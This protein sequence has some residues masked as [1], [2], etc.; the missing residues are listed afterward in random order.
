MASAKPSLPFQPPPLPGA[1]ADLPM[2][3]AN[4]PPRSPNCTTRGGIPLRGRWRNLSIHAENHFRNNATNFRLRCLIFMQRRI[5]S[6]KKGFTLMELLVVMAII[7]ILAALL[8]PALS[9]ILQ[10]ARQ[11]QCVNN[12][13][14][15][16]I[17]L[18]GF[19]SDNHVYPLVALRQPD[20]NDKLWVDILSR[21]G[22]LDVPARTEKPPIYPRPGIWHCPAAYKPSDYE[23]YSDYGYNAYGM[24]TRTD[25]N[26]L[27]LGGHHLW[28]LR[29][30][31]HDPA[32]PINGSEV[33]CPREM[34]AIGDGFAGGNAGIQDS[35]YLLWRTDGVRDEMGSAKRSSARHQGKANVV[36]CD[37]HVESPTLK[38]LFEDTSDAAL[39]R[40]NRDH[41][42]HRE[43]LSP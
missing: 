19:V 12:V 22:E 11:I 38:F 6:K 18:Q 3:A 23:S 9:R 25:T 17:I 13:R 31:E 35:W 7:G 16:G 36:F 1:R 10:R 26:S 24:S 15:L 27:G 2:L 43:K 33:V 30:S 5:A 14:Q 39:A 37:G 34:M 4:F 20:N 8:L 42:P 40:W 29:A 41:L 32:P 21:S 28:M